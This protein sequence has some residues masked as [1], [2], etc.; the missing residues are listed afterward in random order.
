ML[1]LCTVAI[2]AGV[3]AI[4][5]PSNAAFLSLYLDTARLDETISA[6]YINAAP[7]EGH[8]PQGSLASRSPPMLG[9][10]VVGMT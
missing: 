6:T 4:H 10:P 8:F 5:G 9:A 1:T 3:E 2:R 7:Q